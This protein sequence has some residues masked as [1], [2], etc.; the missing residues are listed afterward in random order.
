[1]SGQGNKEACE[2]RSELSTVLERLSWQ[3]GWR[4]DP[5]VV[6]AFYAG[7]EIKEL[8]ELSEAGLLDEFFVFL[9]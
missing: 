1:M 5:Q 2:E 6:Q 9:E 4:D 7:E 3:V 8:H